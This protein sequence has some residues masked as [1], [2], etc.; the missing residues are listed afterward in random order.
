[1]TLPIEPGP[2]KLTHFS[3]Q[4]NEQP[5]KEN[6]TT[7]QKQTDQKTVIFKGSKIWLASNF[8]AEV[9]NPLK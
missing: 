4:N 6:K 8:Y 7:K 3:P 1:M 2:G 9:I 5:G